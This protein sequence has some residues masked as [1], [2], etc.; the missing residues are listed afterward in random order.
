MKNNYELTYLSKGEYE[1]IKLELAPII[2]SLEYMKNF[3]EDADGKYY[4]VKIDYIPSSVDDNLCMGYAILQ[5][6]LN[7]GVCLP[8]KDAYNLFK[9]V[10]NRL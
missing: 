4:L 8:I 3:I 6:E 7:V 5:K 10:I 9:D 2:D 1:T